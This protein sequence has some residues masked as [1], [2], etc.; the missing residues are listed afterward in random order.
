VSFAPRDIRKLELCSGQNPHRNSQFGAR[1]AAHLHGRWA[2]ARGVG[3]HRGG[4]RELGSSR[5]CSSQATEATAQTTNRLRS[6]STDLQSNAH[7]WRFRHA[8]DLARHLGVSRVWA[9]RVLIAFR[10]TN[11][12]IS[13]KG[14]GHHSRWGYRRISSYLR[15]KCGLRV[16]GRSDG[17]RD[18]FLLVLQPGLSSFEPEGHE[19]D[20]L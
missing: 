4:R 17:C 6:T 2:F 13:S 5:P 1:P 16:N 3:G 12:W 10:R 7:R 20:R 9:S 19:P 18:G 15:H 8:S 14:S 11:P